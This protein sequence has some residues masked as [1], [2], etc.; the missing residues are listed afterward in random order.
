MPLTQAASKCVRLRVFARVCVSACACHKYHITSSYTISLYNLLF[1]IFSFFFLVFALHLLTYFFY[2]FCSLYF[3]VLAGCKF[4]FGC[5]HWQLFSVVA[6]FSALMYAKFFYFFEFILH[7]VFFS[8]L[9]HYIMHIKFKIYFILLLVN[10]PCF[11]IIIQ[12]WSCLWVYLNFYI[13]THVWYKFEL[14]LSVIK[15]K[16]TC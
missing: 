13:F 8:V 15:L 10:F 16:H 3:F 6:R 14:K 2:I 12:H 5:C 11:F 1:F 7:I 9:V 4:P